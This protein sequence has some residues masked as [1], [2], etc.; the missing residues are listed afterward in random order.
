MH[1]RVIAEAV[2]WL[3]N[4]GVVAFPTDTVTGLGCRGDSSEAVRS[5]FELKGR[6]PARP[7]VL[8]AA[9]LAGAE[10]SAGPIPGRVR[11]MLERLWPGALT[12]VLPCAPECVVVDGVGRAGTVGVRVPD[13]HISVALAR[14]LGAPL[15]TTS[16]NLSGQPALRCAGDAGDIWGK[17]VFVIDGES[18]SVPSTV[19]DFTVWPPKVLRVGAIGE[20]VIADLCGKATE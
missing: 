2:R 11:H 14:E 19:V 9:D 3:R 15:A 13:H 8:F 18:G 16:A 1:E 10:A 5:I 6:D 4:G 12:A 7:L 20:D 17:R